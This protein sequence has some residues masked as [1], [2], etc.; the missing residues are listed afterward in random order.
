MDGPLAAVA[1]IL[2]IGLPFHV[3]VVREVLKMRARERH[4]AAREA[5]G[6]VEA[7][8][9]VIGRYADGDIHEWV[10]VAGLRYRF[11]RV[12]P[13][14]RACTGELVLP[15]GLVYVRRAEGRAG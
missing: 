2:L 4:E 6:P 5:A 7:Y 1:L 8:G 9:D 12:Q 11:D 3:I 14:A 13:A 15:P 10:S